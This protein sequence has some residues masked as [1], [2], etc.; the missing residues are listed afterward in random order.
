MASTKRKAAIYRNAAR[1][2]ER[3]GCGYFGYA[4]DQAGQPSI[5]YRMPM[6]EDMAEVFGATR[7]SPHPDLFDD[8]AIVALC[9]MATLVEAG[10]VP[11]ANSNNTRTL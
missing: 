9:L 2:L 5:K 4:L 6:Q 7:L 8:H 3:N 1:W 11:R 10:D